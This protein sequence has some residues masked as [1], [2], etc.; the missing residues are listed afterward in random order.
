MQHAGIKF[1][2][3]LINVA[4]LLLGWG[5]EFLLPFYRFSQNAIMFLRGTASIFILFGIGIIVFSSSKF[6]KAKT[7][8]APWEPTTALV[9]PGPSVFSRNPI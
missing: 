1:P 4:F 5:L 6:M 8:V 2:P 9:K 7:P 3:P